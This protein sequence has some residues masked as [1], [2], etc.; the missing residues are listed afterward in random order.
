MPLSKG[1][2]GYCAGSSRIL[3]LMGRSPREIRIQKPV[4]LVAT[5]INIDGRTLR[6]ET[7]LKVGKNLVL[8]VESSQTNK[9]NDN[10]TSCKQCGTLVQEYSRFQFLMIEWMEVHFDNSSRDG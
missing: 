10:G 9:D 2:L 5:T 6:A 8:L 1:S 4:L 3:R 7:R